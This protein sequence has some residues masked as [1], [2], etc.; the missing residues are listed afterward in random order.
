M[1]ACLQHKAAGASKRAEWWFQ[2]PNLVAGNWINHIGQ[3]SGAG[4]VIHM[5]GQPD[6]LDQ[7]P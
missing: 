4:V 1:K 5:L 3:G 2:Q 7:S 6:L